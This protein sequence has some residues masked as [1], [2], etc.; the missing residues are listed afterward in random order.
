MTLSTARIP[1]EREQPEQPG[2]PPLLPRSHADILAQVDA[3]TALPRE[4]SLLILGEVGSG[5]TA[6]LTAALES[7][8]PDTVLIHINPGDQRW[9]WSGFTAMLAAMGNPRLTDDY[10]MVKATPAPEAEEPPD[11]ALTGSEPEPLTESDPVGT[12]SEGE[13]EGDGL[14]EEAP[15]TPS[16]E[17]PTDATPS[18]S[19]S[20]E[21]AP[22]AADPAPPAPP[23]PAEP[24]ADPAPVVEPEPSTMDA[25]G[26]DAAMTEEPPAAEPMVQNA[27]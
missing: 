17:E 23:A 3:L 7:A 5:K 12:L 16:A 14:T 19:D 24:P 11:E 10:S 20:N 2:Q 13:P 8:P 22:P 9:P 4:Q 27:A 1:P 6:L 25:T 18:R 15:A 26:A 21:P